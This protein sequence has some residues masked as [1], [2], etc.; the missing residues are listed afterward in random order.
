MRRSESSAIV[1]L[2]AHTCAADTALAACLAQLAQRNRVFAW[3]EG[4]APS[5][6]PTRVEHLETT[7]EVAGRITHILAGSTVTCMGRPGATQR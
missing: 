7:R 3:G 5:M 6:L 2:A 4:W 1:L